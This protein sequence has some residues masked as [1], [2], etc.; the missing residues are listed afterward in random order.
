MGFI[1]Y[2]YDRIFEQS[3]G[4]RLA[5]LVIGGIS[6]I[7]REKNIGTHF[8]TWAHKQIFK[9]SEVVFGKT[10]L[11]NLPMIRFILKRCFIPA[12][13]FVYTFCKKL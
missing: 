8:F 11:H 12:P 13:Q 4:R 7:E 10:Y 3:L 6:R 2:K 5:F 1:S 9:K